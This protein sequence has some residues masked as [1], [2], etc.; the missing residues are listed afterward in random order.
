MSWKRCSVAVQFVDGNAAFA[1]Q[2]NAEDLAS[3]MTGKLHVDQVEAEVLH[4]GIC[5]LADLMLYLLP[6][7]CHAAVSGNKKWAKAHW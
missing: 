2:V 6:Y 5:E 1:L 3:A 7:C 4:N